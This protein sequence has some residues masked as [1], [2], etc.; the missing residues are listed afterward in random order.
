MSNCPAEK[1]NYFRARNVFKLVFHREHVAKCFKHNNCLI[2]ILIGHDS[3][4]TV[5]T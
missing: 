2:N 3:N 1:V 4:L 5:L